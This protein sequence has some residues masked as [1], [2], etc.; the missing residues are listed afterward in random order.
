M[1]D[2]RSLI[3]ADLLRHPRSRAR[4]IAARIGASGNVVG[5]S[6]RRMRG[7]GLVDVDGLGEFDADSRSDSRWFVGVSPATTRS[8]DRARYERTAAALIDLVAHPG[9]LARDVAGRLGCSSTQ[10]G[11]SLRELQRRGLTAVV[12]TRPHPSRERIYRWYLAG[13]QPAPEPAIE[14]ERKVDKWVTREDLAEMAY[15]SLPRD[16]RRKKEGRPVVW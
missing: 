12:Q 7:A 8:V 15:W 10:A 5:G 16:E 1:S 6:L 13:A 11:S 9:S 14:E 4:D 3:I 2:L